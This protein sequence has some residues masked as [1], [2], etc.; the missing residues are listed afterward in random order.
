M[1]QSINFKSLEY[2]FAIG[3]YVDSITV[4][5]SEINRELE[6][7]KK[8][9]TIKCS[10]EVDVSVLSGRRNRNYMIFRRIYICCL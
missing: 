8:E 3:F 1:E 10:L 5:K 6:K 7:L 4:V 9:G 2:T